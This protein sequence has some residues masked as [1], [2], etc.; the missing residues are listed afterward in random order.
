MQNVF[1]RICFFWL[2]IFVY[3]E[4]YECQKMLILP[5]RAAFFIQKIKLPTYE[6][7]KKVKFWWILVVFLPIV[8]SNFQYFTSVFHNSF[9]FFFDYLS[10]LCK[11]YFWKKIEFSTT[12]KHLENSFFFYAQ[13]HIPFFCKIV[14]T[15]E[16]FETT[17]K[18]ILR[19]PKYWSIF[20][21]INLFI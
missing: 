12:Y 10:H 13:W 19:N 21:K 11:N 18:H 3:S 1:F 8:W 14:N 4:I 2:K 6:N 17:K 16:K 20:A 9:F 15:I 7:L 5:F